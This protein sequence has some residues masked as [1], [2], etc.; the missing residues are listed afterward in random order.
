MDASWLLVERSAENDF[1][2]ECVRRRLRSLNQDRL[3]EVAEELADDLINHSIIIQQAAAYIAQIEVERLLADGGP[4]PA[5]SDWHLETAA[6]LMKT[7][8]AD[9]R[10]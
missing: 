7:M 6:Q 9:P 3:L 8:P 2:R 4:F 1:N 10:Q 5:P